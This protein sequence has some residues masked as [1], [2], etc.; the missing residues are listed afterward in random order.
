MCFVRANPLQG[1]GSVISG[2]GVWVPS[3]RRVKR[4]VCLLIHTRVMRQASVSLWR[5]LFIEAVVW[6]KMRMVLGLR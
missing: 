6:S 5:A 3:N 4:V 1:A 2:T